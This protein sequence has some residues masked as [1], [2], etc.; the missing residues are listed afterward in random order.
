MNTLDQRLK[1]VLTYFQLTG[2]KL[3]K[4]QV[5]FISS[6]LTLA[7][8]DG[9]MEGLEFALKPKHIDGLSGEEEYLA[10]KD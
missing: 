3:T 7:Y 10:L 8:M 6:L 5:D 1:A 2:R 9:K 4:K